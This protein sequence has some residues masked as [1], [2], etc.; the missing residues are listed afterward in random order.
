MT[1]TEALYAEHNSVR[2]LKL[3]G[4]LS[5]AICYDTEADAFAMKNSKQINDH[6]QDGTFLLSLSCEQS[7][8]EVFVP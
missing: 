8:G 7:D 1:G 2:L 3:H 4:D 6:V 5:Y